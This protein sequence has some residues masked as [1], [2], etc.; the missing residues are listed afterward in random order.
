MNKKVKKAGQEKSGK[1]K[2]RV[3]DASFKLG[4]KRVEE[5]P[6]HMGNVTGSWS[7]LDHEYLP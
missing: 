4:G 3:A 6:R 1:D 7:H 5:T 2:K